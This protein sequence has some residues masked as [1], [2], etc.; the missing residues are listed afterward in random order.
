MKPARTTCICVWRIQGHHHDSSATSACK[1]CLLYFIYIIPIIRSKMEILPNWH[2]H[3]KCWF[4][5]LP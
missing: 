1:Y 3:Q 4:Q 5:P 2:G